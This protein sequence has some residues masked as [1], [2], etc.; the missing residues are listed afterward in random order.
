MV[1][2]STAS[3]EAGVEGDVKDQI[4]PR[5]EFLLGDPGAMKEATRSG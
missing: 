1:S 3:P 2:F 4:D 5:E